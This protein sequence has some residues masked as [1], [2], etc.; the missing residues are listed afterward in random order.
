MVADKAN[1]VLIL[2]GRDYKT[3]DEWLGPLGVAIIAE[4]GAWYKEV[5]GEW[6]TRS[7]LSHDWTGD[8]RTV[9]ELYC[10]RTPGA[11]IEEKTHSLAWH[12]RKTE[13]EL[14]QL[15]ASELTTDLRHHISD[16]GLQVNDCIYSSLVF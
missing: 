12:Y 14:G 2:S 4:H 16:R 7:D 10:N 1:T 6:K 5:G 3:L 9:M 13:V 8:V 15:R 11:F